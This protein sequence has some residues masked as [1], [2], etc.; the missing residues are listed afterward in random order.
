MSIQAVQFF[1]EKR[2]TEYIKCIYKYLCLDLPHDRIHVVLRCETRVKHF[3]DGSL[4]KDPK[5]ECMVSWKPKSCD[6]SCRRKYLQLS[7]GLISL[8]MQEVSMVPK[9]LAGAD[10]VRST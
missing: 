1:E 2:N 8:I 9:N 3:P 6:D 5:T 4:V 10:T 7:D